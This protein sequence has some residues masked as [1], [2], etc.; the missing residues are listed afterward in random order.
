MPIIS[1]RAFDFFR[2][3]DMQGDE[4]ASGTVDTMLSHPVLKTRTSS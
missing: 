4:V 3:G 1:L 2:G